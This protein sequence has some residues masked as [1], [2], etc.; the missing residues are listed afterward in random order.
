MKST[1][2]SDQASSIV[3]N[4]DKFLYLVDKP[5]QAS[6]LQKL[7]LHPNPLQIDS[8]FKLVATE[9]SGLFKDCHHPATLTFAFQDSPDLM[10]LTD[11]VGNDYIISINIGLY[12]RL[13][14]IF[15]QLSL[16]NAFGKYSQTTHFDRDTLAELLSMPEIEGV[17]IQEE[18]VS[19]DS[20]LNAPG[21]HK[22]S[23]KQLDL[24]LSKPPLDTKHEFDIQTLMVSALVFTF[25]HELA[26]VLMGH[27]RWSK[28]EKVHYNEHSLGLEYIADEYA[29]R[30]IAYD[31]LQSALREIG[32]YTIGPFRFNRSGFEAVG[33]LEGVPGADIKFN[34]EGFMYR[35]AFAL[36]VLL[37]D[38]HGFFSEPVTHSKKTHPHPEVRLARIID[39]IKHHMLTA[40]FDPGAQ[41]Y[42]AEIWE[43]MF[44][45]AMF[46]AEKALASCDSKQLPLDR[47]GRRFINMFHAFEIPARVKASNRNV[48]NASQATVAGAYE[49]VLASLEPQIGLLNFPKD[50]AGMIEIVDD[51]PKIF[52]REIPVP[53]RQKGDNM[54]G[55][56]LEGAVLMQE[57]KSCWQEGQTDRALDLLQNA[58]AAFEKADDTHSMAVCLQNVGI[59]L[60][61]KGEMQS[62]VKAFQG[63]LKIAQKYRYDDIAQTLNKNADTMLQSYGVNYQPPKK[64]FFKKLFKK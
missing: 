40:P 19:I 15:R 46:T 59:I 56:S 8:G 30:R 28:L 63:A 48:Q 44:A 26:H 60:F 51:F 25:W 9:I 27:I 45:Y 21:T 18:A 37:Y 17:R 5:I 31:I 12:K 32:S 39:I 53:A 1:R 34:L 14:A 13:E 23:L 33:K 61:S 49:N 52:E 3:D 43:T 6:R 38:F 55:K 11:C 42:L 36:E 16:A 7:A 64:T 20:L 50:R 62:A 47:E 35:I 54:A 22:P 41:K 58:I 24:Y 10:A 2:S 4:L 29:A 57:A